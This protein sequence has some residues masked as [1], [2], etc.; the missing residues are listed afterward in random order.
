MGPYDRAAQESLCSGVCDGFSPQTLAAVEPVSDEQL[1]F[2]CG[3]FRSGSTLLEQVL[4][5]HPEVCAGGEINFFNLQAPL[6]AALSLAATP[7]QALGSAYLEHLQTSFPGRQRVTNKR[8]DNFLYLG[9]LHSLFPNAR[10]IHSR[11]QPLDTCLSTYFQQFEAPLTWHTDL[12]DI[13]HYY[14]QYRRVMEFWQAQ[15]KDSLVVLDYEHLVDTPRAALE[16]VLAFLGLDW[17]QACLDFHRLDNRVRTASVTQVRQPLYRH[18]RG[19]W[20]NYAQELEPLREYL[21]SAGIEQ[22]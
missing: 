15:F 11:R 1:I 5:A 12:L 18:S 4:A 13:G 3:M 8:P 22:A 6:P 10:F 19:R 21:Q 14:I 7:L 17:H 2:I 20:R 16:P 9:L